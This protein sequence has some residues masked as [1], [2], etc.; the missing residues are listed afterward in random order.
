MRATQDR[1]AF[2]REP[3]IATIMGIFRFYLLYFAAPS[4]Y[5]PEQYRPR[6]TRY[7]GKKESG[8]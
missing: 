1:Q 4:F 6:I 7:Y 3:P 2:A 8:V 5:L